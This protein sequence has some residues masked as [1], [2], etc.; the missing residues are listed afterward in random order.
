L[1]D[2]RVEKLEAELGE[3]LKKQAEFAASRSLGGAT[4][5]E[6]LEYEVRQEIIEQI[7][8]QLG[9]SAGEA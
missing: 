5:S 7:C 2:I 4:D 6:I 9:H 3:L 8:K 1:K